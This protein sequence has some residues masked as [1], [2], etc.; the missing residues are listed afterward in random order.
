MPALARNY[1]QPLAQ[2]STLRAIPGR[3]LLPLSLQFV[4]VL[5]AINELNG[6]EGRLKWDILILIS[7]QPKPISFSKIYK[8]YHA[9]RPS[10]CVQT[11]YNAFEQLT[12][13]GYIKQ[14]YGY[15]GWRVWSITP[16]GRD[17]VRHLDKTSQKYLERLS[18]DN[19][20]Q[21]E[22]SVTQ[23][24]SEHNVSRQYILK[25]ISQGHLPGVDSIRKVGRS[26]VLTVTQEVV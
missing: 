22:I 19:L 16:A 18:I 25:R 1:T 4:A 7:L 20:L 13:L 3:P 12:D 15:K 2:N 17:A 10:R 23:W 8:T 26:Y 6:I 14:E 9:H 5:Q 11:Y 21:R 24:A